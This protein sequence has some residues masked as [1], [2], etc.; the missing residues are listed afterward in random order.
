MFE[1]LWVKGMW[2]AVM[3]RQC[4]HNSLVFYVGTGVCRIFAPSLVP[5]LSMGG[6]RRAWYTLIADP[7]TFPRG[8]LSQCVTMCNNDILIVYIVCW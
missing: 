3:S 5:R 7:P 2:F 1:V 4:Y 6:W 8:F